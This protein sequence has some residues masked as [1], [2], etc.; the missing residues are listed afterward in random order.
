MFDDKGATAV[1]MRTIYCILCGESPTTA[2]H[3]FAAGLRRELPNDRS[4]VHRLA[5]PVEPGRHRRV[6]ER[7]GS[8]VLD[9]Q[10]KV[11]C[12]ACNS[13][14]MNS[15]EQKAIPVIVR[16]L[17]GEAFSITTAEQRAVID[18]ALVVA[19]VRA[20]TVPGLSF[21]REVARA[22]RNFGAASI[23]V[24]VWIASVHLTTS[25]VRSRVATTYVRGEAGG[26][27]GDAVLLWLDTICIILAQPPYRVNF[28]KELRAFH[29]AVLPVNGIQHRE[30]PLP[31]SVLDTQLI[32]ALE[33]ESQLTSTFLDV[34]NAGP[35]RLTEQVILVSPNLPADDLAREVM[36]RRIADAQ[37]GPWL[38]PR[39]PLR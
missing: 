33:L 28:A 6:T 38:E 36:R 14:W 26:V 10:P 31:A 5:T 25:G 21:D 8:S 18:W 3:L 20:E 12:D 2:A 22:F 23:D 17:R 32:S 13:Q 1:P 27:T 39:G 15:I 29:R 30:W 4:M 24:G 11:L 7:S 9:L 37:Q 19:I 16:L 35:G 34:R